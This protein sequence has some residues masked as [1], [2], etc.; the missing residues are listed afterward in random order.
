LS[1]FLGLFTASGLVSMLDD[2]CVLFFGTHVFTSI[3]GILTFF[4]VL[5]AIAAYGLMGLTPVIPKRFVVPPVALILI[6]FLGTLPV[7]IYGYQWALPFDLIVSYLIAALGLGMIFWLQGGWK[8]RWPLVSEKHLGARAFS[9]LN[10]AAFVLVN[11]FVLLPSAVGYV[12]GCASLAVS[13]YTDGFVSLRPGGVFMQARKYARNDGKTILLF[14]MSHIAEPDFYRSVMQSVSS[15]SVVLLEGV[16]D[17]KHLLKHRLTYQRA[18]KSLHLAE[19]HEDFQPSRGELVRADLDVQD[20]SSN[21]IAVLN[22]VALVHSEG[23]NP[24]TLSVLLQSLPDE[25]DEQQLLDDLLLKRNAHVIQVLQSRLPG[26]DNF[27]IP[28]GAAHMAGLAKEIQ[29]SGFHLVETH[30]YVSIR[31]GGKKSEGSGGGTT[32]H[33]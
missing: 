7:A 5:L 3:S 20:F 13:H 12:G 24:R 19:Q 30:D 18:A 4:T 14:P 6:S 33:D 22:L 31:F 9:W 32:R 10:L 21:T 11:L 27:V 16:T 25:D 23:L 17:T 2:S 8:F 15:N 26:A 28:W 1:V 29:K